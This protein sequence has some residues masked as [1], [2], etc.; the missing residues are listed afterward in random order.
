MNDYERDSLNIQIE[1]DIKRLN[2]EIG[3]HMTIFFNEENKE[4]PDLDLIEN[5]KNEML[6]LNEKINKKRETSY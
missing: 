5:S 1:I 6:S 3:K 2:Q 4:N